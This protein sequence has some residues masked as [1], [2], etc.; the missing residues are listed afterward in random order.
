MCE[1]HEGKVFSKEHRNNIGKAKKGITKEMNPNLAVPLSRRNF[2]SQRMK[3]CWNDPEFREERLTCLKFNS[4]SLPT[5]PERRL[6][7]RLS[8]L[9][10]DEYKYVGDGDTFI[11]GKCPDFININGQ[12]KIIEMFGDYW[13]GEERTKRTKYHEEQRRIRH[14]IKY[15]FRTLIVWQRELKDIRQLKKKLIELHNEGI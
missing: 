10:P 6:R 1:S 13:H 14:F 8:H 2:A 12:K 3:K 15:G 4:C 7:N 11:G 5:K 9:F